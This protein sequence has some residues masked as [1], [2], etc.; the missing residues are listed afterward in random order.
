M[1]LTSS[2]LD[3]LATEIGLEVGVVGAQIAVLHE[4]Q[5]VEGSHGVANLDTGVLVTPDTLFQ[6]GST[7][8]MHTA[9][10]VMQ[11]VEE[12]RI[13]LDVSVVEQLPGFAVADAQATRTVTPRHLM[14][15]SSGI[16]NGPYTDFGRGDD[17]LARYVE[18]LTD[19]PVLFEP[20]EGYGYSNASTNISGRLVEHVTGQTWDCVLRER[21]LEPAGLVHSAT[22]AEEVIW[23]RHSLGHTG[24]DAPAV[25]PHW[26][27]PRSMGPAG[28]TLC[29]SAGD[30]ARFAAIFLNG[31]TARNGTRILDGGSVQQMQANQVDVPPTLLADWWGLGPYGK[32]WD[33][34]PV[35][36]HSGTNRA[37]SSYLLWA[38]ERD[39]AVATVVN[40]PA[41]GY[42]F[43]KKAFAELFASLAGIAVPTSPQP[44]AH[45]EY[46]GSR[47]VGSYVM[48][49]IRFEV[50]RSDGGLTLA[51]ATFGGET[52]EPGRL[53][54]LTP[55]TF[56]PT[57]PAVDGR[58]GWAVAFLGP[59][60]QPA[61]HLL[62]GFFAMRRVAA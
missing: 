54:P 22:S 53:V 26:S 34:T 7:T 62:N 46:D 42:P 24:G 28:G 30:L 41:Y 37:G 57:D 9:L 14:S 27:L 2:D 16:D 56:L 55:T 19:V 1:P 48:S 5:V 20:G 8:K 6:I 35:V 47:L 3:R 32:I 58:R 49:G 33:G 15:M 60:D 31:G 59:D 13:G 17:A 12:G 36:G 23:R 39:V 52:F 45:V 51:G 50:A 38:P 10:L 61:T 11:L 18:A 4:G 40:C 21:L 25:L 44:P 29:Q 43:A